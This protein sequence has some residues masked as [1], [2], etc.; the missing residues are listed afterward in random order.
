VSEQIGP[1][2]NAY[3]LGVETGG[4]FSGDDVHP[5]LIRVVVSGRY[6]SWPARR[7]A[8]LD[9]FAAA[10][11]DAD[12][13]ELREAWRQGFGDALAAAEVAAGGELD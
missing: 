12:D 5:D 11:L 8:L 2:E 13:V 7:W 9:D 6:V 3:L 1:C 10:G 4:R